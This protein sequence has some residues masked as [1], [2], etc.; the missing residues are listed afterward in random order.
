MSSIDVKNHASVEPSDYDPLTELTSEPIP[1]YTDGPEEKH[2]LFKGDALRYSVLVE[3]PLPKGLLVVDPSIF[4][5]N[6][7]R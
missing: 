1:N 6:G 2:A 4:N 7:G 3:P 5:N